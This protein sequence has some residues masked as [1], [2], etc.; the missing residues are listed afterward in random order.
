MSEGD[1]ADSLINNVNGSFKDLPVEI[2]ESKYPIRIEAYGIRSDSGGAGRHRG[3]NGTYRRYVLDADSQLSLWFERS[4]STGWGL[5]GG[6][7]GI[8]PDVLVEEPGQDARHYLKVNSLNLPEGTVVTTYTGGGGGY[9]AA[10][11]RDPEAVCEDARDGY[12]SID[13]AREA[14]GVV[15]TQALLTDAR[16]TKQQRLSMRDAR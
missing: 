7:D 3:G 12:V 8:A 16:L 9:G 13:H 15:L 1:G 4:K 10:L 6:E 2:F 5:F 11:E 14:Y